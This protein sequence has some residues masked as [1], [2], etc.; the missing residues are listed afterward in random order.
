M[1]LFTNSQLSI[2]ESVCMHRKIG[3]VTNWKKV[4]IVAKM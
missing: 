2:I 4:K 1:Q 3:H